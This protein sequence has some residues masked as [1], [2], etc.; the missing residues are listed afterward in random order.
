MFDLTKNDKSTYQEANDFYSYA[1]ALA[2]MRE[3]VLRLQTNSSEKVAEEI[4]E[5]MRALVKQIQE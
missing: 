4:T 2:I 5:A 3:N 1:K